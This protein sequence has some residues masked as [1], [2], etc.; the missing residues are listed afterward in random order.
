MELVPERD[1]DAFATRLEK[2]F[3][4]V[5]EFGSG[6]GAKGEKAGENAKN[7]VLTEQIE[8]DV[9]VFALFHYILIAF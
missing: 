5:A 3:A 1:W 7:K 9:G 2:E 4:S 8:F 6:L